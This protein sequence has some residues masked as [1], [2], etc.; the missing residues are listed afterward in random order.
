MSCLRGPIC[1]HFPFSRVQRCLKGRVSFVKEMKEGDSETVF[2][3][4]VFYNSGMIGS[5]EKILIGL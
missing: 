4:Q 2:G 5:S 1:G 3:W